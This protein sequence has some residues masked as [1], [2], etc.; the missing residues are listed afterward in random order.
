[1]HAITT[2]PVGGILRVYWRNGTVY[3][4][5]G[6]DGEEQEA[7]DLLVPCQLTVTVDTAGVW[8]I[9]HHDITLSPPIR[10]WSSEDGG[11]TWTSS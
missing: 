9:R 7:F 3:F 2:L 5:V 10:T 6:D 11:V 8:S 1:M 4:T